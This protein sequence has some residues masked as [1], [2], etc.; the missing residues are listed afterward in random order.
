VKRTDKVK[1]LECA[2]CGANNHVKLTPH[3]Y[4]KTTY[5]VCDTCLASIAEGPFEAHPPGLAK[6]HYRYYSDKPF[7]RHTLVMCGK[8]WLDEVNHHEGFCPELTVYKDGRRIGAFHDRFKA[9]SGKV[10][11]Q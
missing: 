3:L 9:K 4:Y 6:P 1:L 7:V 2:G 10:K 11:L 5:L 8:K